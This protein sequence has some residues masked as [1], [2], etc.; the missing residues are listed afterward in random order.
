MSFM[1]LELIPHVHRAAHRIGLY[2][3]RFADAEVT[4]GE[5][6]ILAHLRAEGDS[7]IAQL[8]KAFA[9][10]RSTLT[11]ILDR[12]AERGWISREADS[13]DRRTFRVRLTRQGAKVAS[14]IYAHLEKLERSVLRGLSEAEARVF[15][16]VLERLEDKAEGKS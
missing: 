13:R 5:A 1:P 6:H 4:Q 8:H 7:T 10:K 15:R 3:G 9:H 2:I 11:S 12:M 14:R 16:E